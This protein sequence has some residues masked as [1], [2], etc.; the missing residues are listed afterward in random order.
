MSRDRYYKLALN[1]WKQD[2]LDPEKIEILLRNLIKTDIPFEV[3]SM[4]ENLPPAKLTVNL[5]PLTYN[6]ENNEPDS[7]PVLGSYG[8]ETVH[9]LHL[10]PQALTEF[11]NDLQLAPPDYIVDSDG[12]IDLIIGSR[13]AVREL[14]KLLVKRGGVPPYRLYGHQKDFENNE[15]W[16]SSEKL[17]AQWTPPSTHYKPAYS[18]DVIKSLFKNSLIHQIKLTFQGRQLNTLVDFFTNIL[19]D[20]AAGD[21]I[22]VFKLAI[23]LSECNSEHTTWLVCAYEYYLDYTTPE[24]DVSPADTIIAEI[25]INNKNNLIEVSHVVTFDEFRI[26]NLDEAMRTWEISKENIVNIPKKLIPIH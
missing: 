22:E 18:V 15:V 19:L 3:L 8:I 1:T 12:N 7:S 25:K 9:D 13:E 16:N 20:D 10:L 11:F 4:I 24:P 5:F 21:R 14:E 23:V 26:Q 17:N 2:P 6:F